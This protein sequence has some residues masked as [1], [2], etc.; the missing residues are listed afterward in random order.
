MMVLYAE[1]VGGQEI[2]RW[3]RWARFRR[4][5]VRGGEGLLLENPGV[6]VPDGE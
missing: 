1:S 2:G 3:R 4:R 5:R 6:L